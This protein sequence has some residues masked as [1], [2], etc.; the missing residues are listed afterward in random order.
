D[1][2]NLALLAPARR[3]RTPLALFEIRAKAGLNLIPERFRYRCGS[4]TWGE[5]G[6]PLLMV[7]ARQ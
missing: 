7:P 1:W 3:D 5:P 4:A 6:A 2:L